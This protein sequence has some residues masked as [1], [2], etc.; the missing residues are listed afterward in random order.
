MAAM[1]PP[2]AMEFLVPDKRFLAT[3]KPGMRL[4][5]AVRKRGADYL[6]E[7]IPPAK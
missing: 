6:I 7:P 5:A 2:L 1:P 4:T 3:L